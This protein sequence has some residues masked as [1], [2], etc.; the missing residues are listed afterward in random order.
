MLH[1]KQASGS[2]QYDLTATT[3]TTKTTEEEEM[4]AADLVF[5]R[6]LELATASLRSHVRKHLVTKLSHEML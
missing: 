3:T 4:A 6:K 5:D 2:S 1:C